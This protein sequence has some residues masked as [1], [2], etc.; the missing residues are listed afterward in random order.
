MAVARAALQQVTARCPP[1]PC[2]L[3]LQQ[4]YRGQ[5]LARV[6][7]QGGARGAV[8]GRVGRVQAACGPGTPGAPDLP[9]RFV[10]VEH[11][12]GVG[13]AGE[14]FEAAQRGGE[15][16]VEAGEQAGGP[17]G[18]AEPGG[19]EERFQEVPASVVDARLLVQ[20][21]Q[22]FTGPDGEAAQVPGLGGC[23]VRRAGVG[24][25]PGDGRA[26]HRRPEGAGRL[27]H[28]DE[29]VRVA[30]GQPGVRQ[31]VLDQE[32]IAAGQHGRARP[33]VGSGRVAHPQRERERVLLGPGDLH[34]RGAV[35]RVV[36][37]DGTS[38]P[39][40]LPVAGVGWAAVGGPQLFQNE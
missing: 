24:R 12:S 27:R 39:D 34:D 18:V 22:Q 1:S 7:A 31:T 37:L 6:G 40:R 11:V 19:A 29:L 10:G 33:A 28:L 3:R 32:R 36:V 9:V 14:G 2:S 21:A 5:R 35:V 25:G 4:M 8:Q 30:A 15:Y 38:E 23:Q 26:A 16:A 17:V 13:A 20:V